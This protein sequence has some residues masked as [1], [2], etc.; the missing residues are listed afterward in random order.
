MAG[1][2]AAAWG[3]RARVNQRRRLHTE[4]GRPSARERPMALIA[5]Y[6]RARIARR[7]ADTSLD[8]RTCGDLHLDDV[9]ARL[10]RT[11]SALG[12][13]ALYDRLRT[14]PVADH[15]DAFEA[16]VERFAADR[17]VRERLQF[18]LAGLSEPAAYHLCMLAGEDLRPRPWQAV[19]PA[20]TV[21]M[22]VAIAAAPFW[23]VAMLVA[24]C[25][26]VVHFLVRMSI[27]GQTGA[28]LALFGQVGPLLRAGAVVGELR[29]PATGAIVAPLVD[30]LPRLRRLGVFARWAGR[31]PSGNDLVDGLFQ[32][33]NL[34]FLL[35]ANGFY[36]GARELRR[37]ADALLAAAGAVGEADAAIAVASYRAGTD[38]WTRPHRLPAGTTV[39][40]EAL[41]HPLLTDPVANDVLLAPPAGLLLTGANMSGKST[42][43][44]TVGINVVLAQTINTSLASRYAA[45]A[46]RVRSLMGRSDDLI[47]GKSYYLVEAEAVVAMLAAAAGGPP[48]LFLLDELFR[49]TNTVERIA[50]GTAVL[51]QL[52]G[53][54][55]RPGPH[56][57]IAATHDRELVDLLVGRYAPAHLS[58]AIGPDGLTFDYQLRPGPAT[59]RNAIALLQLNGAADA[60]VRAAEALAADL[61]RSRRHE[62]AEIPPGSEEN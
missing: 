61:D 19:F 36:F 39:R 37:C 23:P 7:G 62:V 49:G 34:V 54:A 11:T 30:A 26:V 35:D 28:G 29:N 8:D 46:F 45:P 51:G 12:Q 4:W 20:L 32:Y 13:Q 25:G 3:W 58:D 21:I 53:D 33:L 14:A 16:L 55:E 27:A 2:V 22:L 47:A 24:I 59:T 57:V 41:R 6:H 52:A 5:E 31:S 17:G 44:R 38:G 15:L 40:L 50:A 56:V 60:V 42:L 18:V 1:A 48:H 9:F 10:D 43:L